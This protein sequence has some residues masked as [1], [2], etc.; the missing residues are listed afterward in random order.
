MWLAVAFVPSILFVALLLFPQWFNAPF[1]G[2]GE[3]M[4]LDGEEKHLIILQLHKI[5][6]PFLLRRLKKEVETQLPDKV[7]L[8]STAHAHTDTDT[9]TDTDTTQTRHRHAQTHIQTQTQTHTHTQTSL[10]CLLGNFCNVLLAHVRA[11]AAA[12]LAG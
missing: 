4:Q 7:G 8:H 1:A 3:N 9:D 6:R 11:C 5:L 2:T 12:A 10:V